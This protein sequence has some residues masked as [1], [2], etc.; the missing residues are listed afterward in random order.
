MSTARLETITKPKRKTANRITSIMKVSPILVLIFTLVFN[1]PIYGQEADNKIEIASKIIKSNESMLDSLEQLLV[2]F[3]AAPENYQAT[4]VAMEKTKNGWIAKSNPI[5]A[6][7]G[8]N[9][10]ANPGEKREGDGKSPT[11]LFGLGQL[12]CYEQNVKT[13]IPF[14]QTTDAD[15]WIDDPGSKDYNK[16][17]RGE[18]D[19]KSYENLKL[20]SN[21][22]KYC[23]VIE[24]NTHPVVKNMGS[25]IFFHLGS[26]YEPTSGCVAIDEKNMKF[27]LTWLHPKYKPAIIMGTETIL[28]NGLK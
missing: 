1:C 19:A 14:I 6:S 13:S 18:T 2:V 24:Y 10:F 12:F 11:G 21:A 8:R 26:E 28:L 20:R 17:I 27:I 22:Y 9:G 4:L 3:N 23:M 5:P 16:H 15:K 25:A 7:I